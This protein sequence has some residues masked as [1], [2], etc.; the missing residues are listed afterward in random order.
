[1]PHAQAF[2][3]PAELTVK[4]EEPGKKCNINFELLTQ[5]PISRVFEPEHAVSLNVQQTEP[6][7]ARLDG[8]FQPWLSAWILPLP[9]HYHGVSGTDG[10]F[11]IEN[12]PIGKW[13]FQTWQE[14]TGYLHTKNWKRGR[15]TVEIKPGENDL[16]EI[17]LEPRQFNR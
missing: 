10:T 6:T 4:N 17:R 3:V 8:N 7:P 12:L 14:R 1:M 9:H 13:E 2:Q 5:S 11:K 16:G 15:F